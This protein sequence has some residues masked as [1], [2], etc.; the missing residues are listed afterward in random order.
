MSPKNHP[1]QHDATQNFDGGS[2]ERFGYSW[3]KY[4]QILPDHEEQFRLW[5]LALGEFDWS[6][7]TFLDAGCGIGRNS[8]WPMIY[9]AT[10][11]LSIDLDDRFSIL[12]ELISAVSTLSPSK[13]KVSTN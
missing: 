4:F 3:D 11:G 8:Y 9:G 1:A 7:K 2:P 12:L 13:R 10:G 6:N 5:T